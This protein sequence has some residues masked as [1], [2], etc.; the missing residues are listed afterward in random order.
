MHILDGRMQRGAIWRKGSIFC[1]PREDPPLA[2]KY[3]TSHRNQTSISAHRVIQENIFRPM[4]RDALK[5]VPRAA[6]VPSSAVP[7]R[8]PLFPTRM[9][10]GL[11]T[12]AVMSRRVCCTL[13]TSWFGVSS[14]PMKLLASSLNVCM[15]TDDDPTTPNPNLIHTLS[16]GSKS[17]SEVRHTCLELQIW[18]DIFRGVLGRTAVRGPVPFSTT[19]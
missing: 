12:E 1:G 4:I 7:P 19:G 3:P 13:Y 5:S 14:S 10:R 6:G 2:P 11:K 16:R 17:K 9:T 15:K 8:P 18:A